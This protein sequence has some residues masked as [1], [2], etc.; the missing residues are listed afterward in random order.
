MSSESSLLRSPGPEEEMQLAPHS[1]SSQFNLIELWKVLLR[2]RIIVLSAVI[3]TSV[4]GI[5]YSL[6]VPKLYRSEAQLQILKSDAAQGLADPSQTSS[7][8]AAD[9]LDFNLAVQTQVD[10]LRSRSLALK[11]IQ[12]LSLDKSPDYQL[13]KY[14]RSNALENSKPLADSPK[15]L[16]YVLKLYDKRLATSSV[17][18][19][20]LIAV[21]FLDRSPSRAAQVVNQLLADFIEYNYQVR[22][23]ANTQATAAFAGELKAMKAQVD[24][25]QANVIHL[26]EQS[27]IYGVDEANNATNAKLEQLNS[28]LTAAQANLA[29][30]QSIYKLAT[31]RSPEVL[32]GMLGAQATGA[33]TTNAPLQ[34]LRQQ[35]AEAAANYSELNAHYGSE[36]PKV[37]QAAQRLQSI[38][39][40]INAEIDRLVGQ[41]TAEYTVARDTEASAAR[42]LQEQKATAAQMNHASTVYTSAKH[43]ADASRDLYEQL[44]KR[45]KEAGILASLRS[46][47]L[48]ILDAAIA[49]DQAAQPKPLL[50]LVIFGFVGLFLGTLA[51][52]LVDIIDPSIRDPQKIEEL[53]GVRVIAL[54]PN[55]ENSLPLAAIQSLQRGSPSSTWQYQTTARA[56][57]SKVAETFRVLRTAILS[58]L[59]REGKRVLAI[60][61]PSE[62]EGKSLVTFNLAAALAQSGRTVVVVDADLRKRTLTHALKLEDKEGLDEASGDSKWRQYVVTYEEVPGL[63]VLPAGHQSHYPSDVLGSPAVEKLLADL[64]ASFDFVLIDTPSVLDVT[65]TVALSSIV[66]GVILTARFGKTAQHSLARALVLLRRGKAKII[67]IVLNG[68]DFGSA[69]FYYYWGRQSSGYAANPS[70][71]LVPATRVIAARTITA[72][73]LG[74][75]LGYHANAQ[76]SA[77]PLAG[78]ATSATASGSTL[79]GGSNSAQKTLIGVGD[80]LAINVFDAPELSQ[81]VRVG[82]EGSVHLALLGDVHADGLQANQLAKVLETEMHDRNLMRKAQ[83]TVSIKEFTTQGVTVEGEVK[84]PGL[85]PIYSAR[86]L[87]DVIAQ[88]DGVTSAADI[89]ITIRRQGTNVIK[90]VT[91]DQDNG[92]QVADSDV[93]VYPGDTVIVPRA[94]FAYVLGDVQRPGGYIMHDN[95]SMTILQAVSEAQGTTHNASLK[96]VILLHKENGVL[97]TV[98]IELKAMQRGHLP[99]QALTAGD[100]V[101]VPSSGLKTFA[102][103]TEGIAASISGAAL[104][105]VGR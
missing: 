66:D 87:V 16:A 84:K 75:L 57:R 83:V 105:T 5:L 73:I 61:S 13:G 51:A 10:V 18:G 31:T 97:K 49:P 20:R 65:D 30:K 55:I 34:L 22:L 23:Q 81:E 62:G 1:P 15:H 72:L 6:V 14:P 70:Q 36:Y 96:H 77:P 12:E 42:A 69:D 92:A 8:A 94:G 11:I 95:G 35:Q 64:R 9:A 50:Y 102:S 19:T 3:A 79:G 43:D 58:T 32:A 89:H 59:P 68:M 76:S 25:S 78:M 27:G 85:Y 99:D 2:R 71:I 98:P 37:L 44:V 53:L 90:S 38:Q 67:G 101:F 7:T 41:A 39:A 103:G 91:F 26:Q 93:R 54:I 29:I 80:L 47:N 48:N 74:M 104:Y 52:F 33:N 60:T 21:S 56:P 40:S 100:I 63:F 24:T 86:S 28:Q 88:A 4:L 45:L 17:S 46:T 82:S